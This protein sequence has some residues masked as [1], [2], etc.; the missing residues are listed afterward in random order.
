MPDTAGDLVAAKTM[1]D[2]LE[3]RIKAL[4]SSLLVPAGSTAH[5]RAQNV[6]AAEVA[7]ARRDTYLGIHAKALLIL[8]RAGV[9]TLDKRDA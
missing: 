7:R 1:L 9:E 6:S 3:R 5:A 8:A 4:D 2:E